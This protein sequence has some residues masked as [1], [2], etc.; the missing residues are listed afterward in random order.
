MKLDPPMWT[1][2][3]EVAF[4]L[5]LPLLGALVMR[6]R[7]PVGVPLL[8]VGAGLVYNW[9][10]AGRGLSQPWTKAL[11]ALLPLFGVGMLIAHLPAGAG[12]GRARWLVIGLAAMLVAGDA[13]WHQQGAGGLG[14]VLRDLPAAAGFALLIVG[15]RDA[16]PARSLAGRGLAWIGT[17]SF[18]LYLWHVPVI[19]WLRS[20]R[21]LPLDPVAALPLVLALSLGLAAG[22]WYLVEQP[23]MRIVRT[24]GRRRRS[25]WPA[26]LPAGAGSRGP[27]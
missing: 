14:L 5:V 27:C 3:V 18:G 19:W 23:V 8:A 15:V 26:S 10:I 6:A 22:S 16:N 1:L 20:V 9:A 13:A 11:P 17:V 24:A 25:P 7:W 4:Y 12:V 2:A 21:L